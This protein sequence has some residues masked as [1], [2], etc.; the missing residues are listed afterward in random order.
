MA[1]TT[2]RGA[3]RALA[4]LA[5]TGALTGALVGLQV[6]AATAAETFGGADGGA[7][8]AG[9][10]P[11][12]D[13][14]V[15]AV[16]ASGAEAAAVEAV[17]DEV[18]SSPESADA[19][20]ADPT[21][22]VG[23]C[24]VVV[25]VDPA[26]DGQDRPATSAGA[27]GSASYAAGPDDGHDHHGHDHHGHDAAGAEALGAPQASSSPDAAG[28]S[29]TVPAVMPTGTD[30]LALSSRPGAPK[31]IWVDVRGGTLRDT[32]WNDWLESPAVTSPA[33]TLDSTP[34]ALNATEREWVYRIWSSVAE[35]YAPFDVNVTTAVPSTDALRRSGSAD[36]VY[37]GRIIVTSVASPVGRWD[38][39]GGCAGI[40]PLGS[41]GDPRFSG[42]ADTG[43]AF[44]GD[45]S[46]PLFTGDTVS[47]E[48]G[49]VLAL[50][51]DGDAR[52]D[53]YWGAGLWG[54]IMGSPTDNPVT[55]WSIG[56]YPGANNQQDDTAVLARQLG[57][58]ADDVGDTPAAARDLP[59]GTRTSGVIGTRQDVDVL[60][61]TGDGT[62]TDVT[63]TTTPFAN[64]D[65]RLTVR[66]QDGSVVAA[67]DP[68]PGRDPADGERTVGLGA[69]W[70]G[71]IPAGERW[72]FA[73][74]GTS[75]GQ[76]STPGRWSDY[77]SLGGWTATA[78]GSTAAPS[79]D[80][81]SDVATL[82]RGLSW[83]APAPV[84]TGLPDARFTSTSLPPGL[85]LDAATGVLSGTPT[86]L[87]ATPVTVTATSG[88]RSASDTVE[89][90]VVEAATTF[91]PLA[92]ARLMDTRAGQ[93]TVDGRSAG[94][95]ALN[96]ST[97]RRLAV[98]GRG[99]V[100]AS[101]VGAVVLNVTATRATTAGHLTVWP[102]GSPRPTAS[103]LN[104]PAGGT[105]PN[106]VVAQVG[107]GGTVEIGGAA[108][109][110]DVVVDVAGWL[111][112][113]GDYTPLTPARV[114]DTRASGT[115]VDGAAQR[116]G[117]L[118]T[119]PRR[120]ALAG[121]AGVPS[122]GVSAVVLNVTAVR[123]S[124]ATH[125]TAWPSGQPRPTASTLNV[126][127]GATRA[128]LAVVRLGDDGA[129]E[130]ANA[131]G[132]ADV[133]LDVAGWFADDGSYT[134]LVPARL[135]DTR[136]GATTVDGVAAGAGAIGPGQTRRLVVAGR[137]GVPLDASAV[138]LNVTAVRP[139]AASHLTVWPSG[140]Q[141]PAS[142]NLNY[143]AGE[144]VANLVVAKV[145]ADGSIDLA[146]AAGGVHVVVDVAGWWPAAPPG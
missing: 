67:V 129:I 84:V 137:N 113:G 43:F 114:L 107:E 50:E 98:V 83:T 75:Y 106:V 124:A 36:T 11:L 72:T 4:T 71:T 65:V 80:L 73:L 46:T 32:V 136:A 33:F 103:N 105:V 88:A 87:G 52:G 69:T 121:R 19:L 122:S 59:R 55:Q 62:P 128:N 97:P 22:W 146:N 68:V 53:Y 28:T 12:L 70:G 142:S 82:T 102:T 96:G 126:L 40:A 30:V 66:N 101:G 10:T 35:D 99:G 132:S 7:C 5:L 27:G 92:P 94:G 56:E 139:S 39:C 48:M 108:G 143:G 77:G 42:Y 60:A 138:V 63:V 118:G 90:R 41:F 38:G 109:N 125:L 58:S 8:A 26:P 6:P 2:P 15:Q 86:T 61:V 47:H 85:R 3:A 9:R 16:A 116:E 93:P 64:L 135:M 119:A 120:V 34:S 29:A 17:V 24:D 79:L 74:D 117:A 141:K 21:T 20:L 18:A 130:L 127:A 78:S 91:V 140:G 89:V 45:Y 115:T 145:G 95:G 13:A 76:P 57:R 104:V 14:P 133:V 49:H 81:G 54:A 134:P 1:T 131:A 111:P 144:V 31:T 100:P 110:V 51:H 25:A 23:A 44:I 112:A 123:P 37:G